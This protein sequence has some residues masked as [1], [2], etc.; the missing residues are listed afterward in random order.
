MSSTRRSLP[1]SAISARRIR[2]E[3]GSRCSSAPRQGLRHRLARR[4]AGDVGVRLDQHHLLSASSD[5]R[6][7]PRAP[8]RCARRERSRDE[9]PGR[10]SAPA[11][12][13][14]DAGRPAREARA[15][16]AT[17]RRTARRPSRRDRR[18]WPPPACRSG[19][20]AWPP[21][22]RGPPPTRRR[23]DPGGHRPAPA[24]RCA[25][26]W[27]RAR[28]L[29]IPVAMSS[30]DAA[31][32]SSADCVRA[33]CRRVSGIHT[34]PYS[35]VTRSRPPP[36]DRR[37]PMHGHPHQPEPDRAKPASEVG[38][39]FGSSLA[40]RGILTAPRSIWLGAG[41][42][43]TLERLP[44]AS[45]GGERVTTMAPRAISAPGAAPD[46][47]SGTRRGQDR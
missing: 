34:A 6:R 12:S 43:A 27:R 47:H 29:A 8:T 30:V 35:P 10:G 24:R 40:I 16:M 7:A 38:G 42:G 44:T 46:R 36:R 9:H 15:G 3:A 20:R 45:A 28:M 21:T 33:P 32:S 11:R 23:S 17:A 18:S 19:P 1:P 31:A 13:C 22:A 39:K 14:A 41:G 25:R 4:A 37:P 2:S 5:R 26:P